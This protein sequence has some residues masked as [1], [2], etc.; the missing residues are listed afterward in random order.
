MSYIKLEMFT[1]SRIVGQALT[2]AQADSENMH[3]AKAG[4]PYR[5]CE[6]FNDIIKFEEEERAK[7]DRKRQGIKYGRI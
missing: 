3:L 4:S 2:K 5:W 1:R 6:T 7:Q